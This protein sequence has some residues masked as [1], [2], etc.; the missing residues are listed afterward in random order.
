[1]KIWFDGHCTKEDKA[2]KFTLKALKYWIRVY[3]NAF[4][5]PF[6]PVYAIAPKDKFKELRIR[7]CGHLCGYWAEVSRPRCCGCTRR[8]PKCSVC[9]L[10]KEGGAKNIETDA[11]KL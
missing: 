2:E 5:G 9:S 7:T 11:K 6:Y 1:M 3:G 8:R 10:R 4:T